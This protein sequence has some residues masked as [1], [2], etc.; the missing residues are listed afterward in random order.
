[1]IRVNLNIADDL[2]KKIDARAKSLCINRSAYIN[3][4]LARQVE[5]DNMTSSMPDMLEIMNK[6]IDMKMTLD[7]EQK[8]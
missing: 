1:M 6:V 5:V 3:L 7:G 2:L 8:K 4:A